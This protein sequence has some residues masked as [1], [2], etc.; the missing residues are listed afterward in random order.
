MVFSST[1]SDVP[2]GVDKSQKIICAPFSFSVS[3]Y[4]C[5]TWS[6]NARTFPPSSSPSVGLIKRISRD[7]CRNE[8]V[9]ASIL[10]APFCPNPLPLLI[11]FTRSAISFLIYIFK[12]SVGSTAITVGLPPFILGR[13]ILISSGLFTSATSRNCR[14]IS[15][16]L[17]NLT[18]FVF[19]QPTPLG[20]RS[21]FV[22]ICPNV[23]THESKY[24]FP[25]FFKAS[26]L[27]YRIIVYISFMVLLIG[28]PVAN[29]TPRP[30]LSLVK[31]CVFINISIADC[32]PLEE[33]PDMRPNFVANAKFLN[34]SASSTK[35]WSM[36]KSSNVMPTSFFSTDIAFS[37]LACKFCFFFS[38]SFRNRLEFTSLFSMAVISRSANSSCSICS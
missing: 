10:S 4:T 2:F 22:T 16:V 18:A 24:A 33:I 35:I 14:T 38:K 32:E 36:P 11:A 12:A 17:A 9:T 8:F 5:V 29:T 3:L 30:L 27:R 19:R 20:S 26:M 1:L 28:V 25:V 21:C 37:I 13:L 23:L 7:A 31:Y 6:A 15:G 34:L